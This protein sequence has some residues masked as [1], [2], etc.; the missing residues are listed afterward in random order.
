MKNIF[1]FM[2]IALMASALMVSCSKDKEEGGND[3]P[4][5]Q[6]P[7]TITWDGA[8]A[9]TG[10]IDGYKYSENG[11]V[12]V[13]LGAAGLENNDYTFP[14]YRFGFDLDTDPQYGCAL[15]AQWVYNQQYRGNDVWPTDVV[16]S[17]YYASNNDQT[18]GIVG[19]WW[20]DQFTGA[21]EDFH[22]TNAQFDATTR[23]LSGSITVPLFSYEDV[24]GYLAGIENYT[25][26]DVI[27]AINQ[28]PKKNLGVVLNNFVFDAA[29]K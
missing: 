26:D 9:S 17:N 18:L 4:Q 22:M 29:Q 3:N 20:L 21:V 1:K 7:C 2:G 11:T 12:Y 23:T 8:T 14:L 10:V 25:N 15:T 16:E 28:A 6:G 24:Q 5:P 19:D 27:T 13:L